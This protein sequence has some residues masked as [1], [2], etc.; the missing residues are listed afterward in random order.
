MS[1]TY[2]NSNSKGHYCPKCER[3]WKHHG[4]A[5]KAARWK[6]TEQPAVCS[7][8]LGDQF[9]D[10]SII[11]IDEFDVYVREILQCR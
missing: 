5:S 1:H 10:E 7:N 4:C 3:T 2:D 8:C 9:K 11:Y 6:C